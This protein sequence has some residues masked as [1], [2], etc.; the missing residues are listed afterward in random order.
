M[1]L[2]CGYHR[3][4][5]VLSTEGGREAEFCR[6]VT[7]V[8]GACLP[9]CTSALLGGAQDCAGVDTGACETQDG[10]GHHEAGAVVLPAGLQGLGY[11]RGHGVAV[12]ECGRFAADV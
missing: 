10:V 1:P 11:A 9:G 2:E 7:A 8:A 12:H 3:A 4:A 6:L 5:L